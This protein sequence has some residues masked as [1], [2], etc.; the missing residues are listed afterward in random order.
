MS[1]S[2]A[3]RNKGSRAYLLCLSS[4]NKLGFVLCR[5]TYLLI[6]SMKEFAREFNGSPFLTHEN[7]V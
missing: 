4:R 6:A 3:L 2:E 1:D 7:V 5:Y